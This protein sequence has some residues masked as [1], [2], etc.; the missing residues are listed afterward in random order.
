VVPADAPP[1]SAEMVNWIAWAGL[2][3]P[4]NA[5]DPIDRVE[6]AVRAPD[7]PAAEQAD[8]SDGGITLHGLPDR[9]RAGEPFGAT[10]VVELDADV[11]A[12][13]RIHLTR[14]RTYV[15][16][17]VAGLAPGQLLLTAASAA[18]RP[19]FTNVEVGLVSVDIAGRQ[20]FRAGTPVSLPFTVTAPLDAGP[21]TLYANGQVDWVVAAVLDRRMHADVSVE[22]GIVVT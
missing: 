20:E 7:A 10:V 11:K 8:V 6:I 5:V 18:G 21:S 19:F 17:P 12:G 1:T 13:V 4:A 3:G 15:P 22:T 2:V 16:E 14:R 9:V